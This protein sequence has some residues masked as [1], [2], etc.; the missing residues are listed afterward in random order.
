MKGKSLVPFRSLA[1]LTPHGQDQVVIGVLCS[2]PSPCKKMPTGGTAAE[3]MLT[4]L[5]KGEAHQ[6]ALLLVGDAAASWA[7][8]TGASRAHATVGSILALLN[9]INCRNGRALRVAAPT[10]VIKL[11]SCPSL[12][13]CSAKLPDGA[14]CR[15]PYNRESGCSYCF[16]HERMSF[17]ERQAEMQTR[18]PKRKLLS[19]W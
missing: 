12:A 9:P 14:P 5:D 11:G 13:F 16:R 3:W 7:D 8:P 10:Q 19:A 18:V 1:A 17:V 15:G 6:A 2:P 4:D